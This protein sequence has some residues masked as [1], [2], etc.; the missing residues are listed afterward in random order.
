MTVHEKVEVLLVD[1]DQFSSSLIAKYLNKADFRATLATSAK[2]AISLLNEKHFP[3]VVSDIRLGGPD[4]LTL[5]PYIKQAEQPCLIIFMT[6][7]GSLNT[8]VRALSEGAFDYISKSDEFEL[9]ELDLKKVMVR[10][11]Q[12]LGFIA[13]T[14]EAV[15]SISAPQAIIGESPSMVKLYR[16][17]A[18]TSQSKGNVLILGESGTG[19]ELVAHAIH[20][21]GPRS[22]KPFVTVNCSALTETLLES[23]LFGHVKGAFTGATSNK[24]GLFEVANEGTI[25]LDEIGDVSPAMQVKLLRAIQQGE[26]KPVGSTESRNVDVRIIAATH[27][28]LEAQ[29][30]NGTF[31]EDLYYRLKVF[32][33]TIPALR[34]RKQDIRDLV[35]HFLSR[36]ELVNGKRVESISKEA[37]DLLLSYPW[38][39]NIR[40]LEN[41]I[42]RAAGMA[43]TSILFPEDF[44]PELFS[45][46][47]QKIANAI[48][49]S[50]R[51]SSLDEVVQRVEREHIA[52]TLISTNYNKSKASEIL[53]I[54]R[55]TLYRKA[56]QYGIPLKFRKTRESET[57]IS[58]LLNDTDKSTETDV[59]SKAS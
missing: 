55:G 20:A 8:A 22:T 51:G 15:P 57:P 27:R 31:R 19:K 30:E 58:P 14:E 37:L 59:P 21:N 11:L 34:D 5:L 33:I 45:S 10:A 43:S 42:E 12:Q 40:E 2:Q 29:I 28:N 13:S 23:E 1:D 6:G 24:K 52:Q 18:K 35:K 46:Q 47:K 16:D 38:P 4:G 54:D 36:L 39:G 53:G 56:M 41:A 26:I 32:L 17:I 49:T 50:T 25:F 7:H 3:I 44:P 9:T 48:P